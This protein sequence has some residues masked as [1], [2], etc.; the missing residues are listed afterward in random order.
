MDPYRIAK[1]GEALKHYHIYASCMAEAVCFLPSCDP[2]QHNEV[3][4]DLLCP[5]CEEAKEPHRKRGN[6]RQDDP[7]PITLFQGPTATGRG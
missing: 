7:R 5:T 6:R 2:D 1:G 3:W 4:E